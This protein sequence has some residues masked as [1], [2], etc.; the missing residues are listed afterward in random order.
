MLYRGEEE[1]LVLVEE[2]TVNQ[3]GIKAVV[4]DLVF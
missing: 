2:E 1:V 4:L 3:L